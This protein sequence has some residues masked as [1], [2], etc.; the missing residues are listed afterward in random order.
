MCCMNCIDGI[1]SNRCVAKSKNSKKQKQYVKFHSLNEAEQFKRDQV[2]LLI[3]TERQAK[4]IDNVVYA[5][6]WLC[7]NCP[8][9]IAGCNEEEEIIVCLPI[10]V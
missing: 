4:K 6:T 7:G 3:K 8:S 9:F 1:C 2:A 5:E 10:M